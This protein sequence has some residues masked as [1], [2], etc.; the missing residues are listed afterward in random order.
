MTLVYTDMT[1]M[2]CMMGGQVIASQ[3]VQPGEQVKRYR[4]KPVQ[5]GVE[6]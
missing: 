4:C 6:A 1:L 3:H 2:E 5:Q